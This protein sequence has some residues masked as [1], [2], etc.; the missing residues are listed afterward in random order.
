M[1]IKREGVARKKKIRGAIIAGTV[2]AGIAAISFALS[3]LEP[4]A[5]SVNRSTVWT[6]GVKRGEMIRQV[7]G[8]GTL[9][10]VPEAISWV[11]ARTRGRVDRRVLLPGVEV[12][13]DTIILELSNPE[14][15]QELRDAEYQLRAQQAELADLRVTVESQLLNQKSIAATVASEYTQ[16]RLQAEADTSLH[17]EKLIGELIL[18]RSLVRAEE[19]ATRK[20]IEQQRL[21][22]ATASVDAQLA[23]KRATVEQFRALYDLRRSQKAALTVRA[24]ISGVLQEVPVEVGQEVTPGANLARV[25]QPDKLKAQLRIAETQAKDIEV[26]Q[27]AVIDTRNGIIDGKVTRIDPAVQEGT[28]TVDVALVGPL[29]KGARPDLSV[30][31]TIELERLDDVLYVGRP[32]YGQAESTIGLFKLLDD[33]ETAVRTQVRLGRSSVNTIEVIKGLNEGDQVILSDTSAWD[34][35]NRIRLK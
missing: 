8:P 14:L 15:E 20:E 6:D 7:R 33:G 22:I 17:A 29:P 34:A 9:E 21:E 27:K 5:P 1:D 2:L 3:R 28:V 4:A 18:K 31:G 32:A 25:A 10:V 16:A 19:L 26:G 12:E 11:A 13:P 23:A 35:Y 24:G 30:D